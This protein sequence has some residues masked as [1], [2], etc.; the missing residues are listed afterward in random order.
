MWLA[1][2]GDAALLTQHMGKQIHVFALFAIRQLSARSGKKTGA[3][4]SN[5]EASLHYLAAFGLCH[6]YD[7]EMPTAGTGQQRGTPRSINFLRWKKA[8][9]R[10]EKAS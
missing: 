10:N 2:A 9:L 7:S 8:A 5:P 4:T 1:I 6:A 3:A